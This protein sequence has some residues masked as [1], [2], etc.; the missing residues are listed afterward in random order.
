M[1]TI[2]G[3]S[4]KPG[5]REGKV[6]VFVHQ[7]KESESRWR[8]IKGLRE[9][10]NSRYAE[11]VF[12]KKQLLLTTFMQNPPKTCSVCRQLR[13]F[14]HNKAKRSVTWS[15]CAPVRNTFVIARWSMLL[16]TDGPS[17]IKAVEVW[18][19]RGAE[20]M[21]E[22]RQLEGE[23]VSRWL[24]E[25]FYFRALHHTDGFFLIEHMS[26]AYSQVPQQTF[27]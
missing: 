25:M 1:A 8:W 12:R 3:M 7:K 27:L 11:I 5:E 24:P 18:T 23:I 22:G 6:D 20:G 16:S 14:K 13:E 21:K 15:V 19:K 17:E 9:P 10:R 4:M 2:S 26:R